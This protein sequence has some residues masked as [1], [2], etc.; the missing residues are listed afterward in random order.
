MMH[1][2]RTR[3]VIVV[4]LALLAA[5][6]DRRCDQVRHQLLEQSVETSASPIV[7]LEPE[8]VLVMCIRQRVA[9]QRLLAPGIVATDTHL[10]QVNVHR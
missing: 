5:A 10:P 9:A 1:S 7:E 4:C 8:R 2:I 6:Y 3:G